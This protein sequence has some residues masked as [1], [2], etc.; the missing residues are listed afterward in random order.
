[1]YDDHIVEREVNLLVRH[2]TPILHLN[3]LDPDPALDVELHLLDPRG[4]LDEDLDGAGQG[5]ASLI[6]PVLVVKMNKY[7]I[8]SVKVALHSGVCA[9]VNG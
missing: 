4:G 9:G 5:L 2:V 8:N 3:P 7:V 6:K 1:M